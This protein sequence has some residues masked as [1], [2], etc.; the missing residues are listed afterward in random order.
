MAKL[1][2]IEFKTLV[3]QYDIIDEQIKFMQDSK[4]KMITSNNITVQAF[5]SR[6]KS[7]NL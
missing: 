4:I 5:H 1:T 6:R 2:E 3:Y 7:M